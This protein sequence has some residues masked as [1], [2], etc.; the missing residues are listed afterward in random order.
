MTGIWWTSVSIEIFLCSL[1]ATTAHLLMSLGQTR[2]HACR[3]P[4]TISGSCWALVEPGP[5]AEIH[6]TIKLRRT[7]RLYWDRRGILADPISGTA[8]MENGPTEELPP[9]GP[10]RKT[11]RVSPHLVPKPAA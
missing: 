8:G 6:C 1:T 7:P 9:V 3:L 10:K 2:I 5:S 11:P 4:G